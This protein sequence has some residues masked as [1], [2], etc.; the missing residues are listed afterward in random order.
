MNVRVDLLIFKTAG[1]EVD[2]LD[3]RVHGMG[4]ENVLWLEIAVNDFVLLEH[5]QATQELF[6]KTPNDFKAEAAE[7]VG[8][9][10]LVQVHVK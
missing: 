7:L 2:D 5:Y 3:L 4:E 10:E 8:L 9:D 1:T 6:G